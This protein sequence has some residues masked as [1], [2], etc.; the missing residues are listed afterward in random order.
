MMFVCL[1]VAALSASLV[2]EAK[3]TRKNGKKADLGASGCARGTGKKCKLERN[4]D[5]DIFT[6][7]EISFQL[8]ENGAIREFVGGSLQSSKDQQ[9]QWY[10]VSDGFALNLVE[11]E[12]SLYGSASDDNFIYSISMDEDGSPI[13]SR[14]ATADFPDELDDD[15]LTRND[16][17]FVHERESSRKR[18]LR[19]TSSIS[20]F[21]N[22]T[23][24]RELA[25]GD[26]TFDIMVVWTTNAECNNAG[27]DSGCTTTPATKASMRGLIDLA[28]AETN[29][30]FEK[31]GVHAKVRLVDAYRDA[32][33]NENGLSNA[34]RDITYTGG[35]R[36]AL[37]NVHNKRAEV[38]ADL[39]AMIIHDP[40]A[41]G[42][43]WL[44]PDINYMFSVTHW[45][46]ATGYFSFGHEIGHNLVSSKR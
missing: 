5:K 46:C 38:G 3:K 12:G 43:A 9:P 41:C 32:T 11:S 39:V 31:S 19:G 8:E 6:A 21:I 14:T 7:D 22:N 4:K 37:D 33:Y 30:A 15:D 28:V 24:Q 42:V 40:A 35:N 18:G 10:G 26:T 27:R 36:A 34:L 13:V 29:V 45:K 16:D 23:I 17:I 20:P 1:L 25:H 44:G 2:A